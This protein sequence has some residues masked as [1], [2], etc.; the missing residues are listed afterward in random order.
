MTEQRQKTARV[1]RLP[2]QWELKQVNNFFPY[3]WRALQIYPAK[4]ITRRE[5]IF[6]SSYP[7]C[8]STLLFPLE[9]N[10]YFLALATSGML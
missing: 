8:V 10:I 5:N 4:Q 3:F 7:S 9:I 2:L 6:P 1:G